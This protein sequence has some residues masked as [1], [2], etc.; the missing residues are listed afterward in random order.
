MKSNEPLLSVL[1]MA[2]K[3]KEFIMEA[4]KSVLNQSIG[5]NNYE[6]VCVIGFHDDELSLFFQKNN[7]KELFC[8]GKMGQTITLG[9][10]ACNSDVIVFI[11]DDDRFRN[12][13]LERVLQAFSNY[14]CNYYHNNVELIDQKSR[15]ILS[16]LDPYDVQLTRSFIWDTTRGYRYILRH[17]GDFNMSSIAV[18]KSSLKPHMEVLGKIEASPDSII[19]FLLMEANMRFMF[20][21]EKT[22]FY[23]VHNSETNFIGSIDP[24]KAL[25]TSSRFYRSRLIAYQAMH[26]PSVRRI[27]IAYVL[28]SKMGTYIAGQKDLKPHLSEKFRFFLIALT[29]P[30]KFYMRLLSATIL[31]SIFPDYVKRVMERRRLEKYKQMQ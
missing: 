14:N 6:I 19:F 13:K 22:T 7:I 23:R 4:I 27:F 9:L 3:R 29:R 11:E 8:D 16:A 31:T 5:I 15:P 26:S 18:R 20:D 30:S 12:D 21:D 1:V 25:D 17:R 28:E 10:Q 24:S 2:Y